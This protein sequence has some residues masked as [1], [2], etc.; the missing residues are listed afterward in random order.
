MMRVRVVLPAAMVAVS[1]G[2]L[3]WN[4]WLYQTSG[5]AHRCDAPGPTPAST[6]LLA[7]NA[8]IV[9][10]RAIWESFLWGWAYEHRSLAPF[11][12][13]LSQVLFLAA[14]GL[15]WCW[16][17]LNIET[18]RERNTVLMFRWRPGRLVVDALLVVSGLVCGLF[19]ASNLEE[20]MG[21]W[22]MNLSGISCFAPIWVY[23]LSSG[24]EAGVLLGWAFALV[25][26]YGRDFVLCARRRVQAP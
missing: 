12:G 5:Y 13:F 10:P 17:A 11:L 24:I 6:V 2:L 25:F 20:V 1:G 18:W 15:L 4:D 7:I 21:W 23:M 8:P 22:P 19:A 3:W 14:I 16:V 9:L 26:F